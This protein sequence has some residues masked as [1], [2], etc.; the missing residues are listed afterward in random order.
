MITEKRYRKVI[1]SISFLL[2]SATALIAQSEADNG[3]TFRIIRTIQ[4]GE[5]TAEGGMLKG[6]FPTDIRYMS[7]DGEVELSVGSR[8]PSQEHTLPN[9]KTLELYNWIPVPPDAPEGTKPIKNI[10]A[11]IALKN[12]KYQF[13]ILTKNKTN[14]GFPLSGFSFEDLDEGHGAGQARLINLSRFKVAMAM[15]E[16]R[17]IAKPRT[18]E[19]IVEFAPG[20]VDIV[21]AIEINENGNWGKVSGNKLRLSDKVKVYAIVYDFPPSL[22]YPEPVRVNMFTE[23]AY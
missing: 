18:T 7:K 6:R 5:L 15:E 9:S 1:L 19:S 20:M 14:E 23:R 8:R 21:V 17:I 16:N 3:N 11:Q 4:P 10:L 12:T 13:V 2:L 22:E